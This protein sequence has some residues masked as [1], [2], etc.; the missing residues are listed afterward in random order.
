MFD[1]ILFLIASL[2]KKE[3]KPQKWG[4]L[5]NTLLT[6]IRVEGS[7]L[8]QNSFII[9]PADRVFMV[10]QPSWKL[11]PTNWEIIQK[12]KAWYKCIKY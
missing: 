1:H 8:T 3:I 7:F 5:G 2:I 9:G 10:I 4:T 11:Y 6:K 12:W